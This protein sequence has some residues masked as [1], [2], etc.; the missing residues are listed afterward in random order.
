MV[1]KP[2]G[3][4]SAVLGE[5]QMEV[6]AARSQ[7]TRLKGELA[8]RTQDLVRSCSLIYNLLK[9]QG[10]SDFSGYFVPKQE[11]KAEPV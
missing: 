4:D 5:K 11:L 9:G 3:I 1:S 10:S 6:D 8:S 7:L 2:R